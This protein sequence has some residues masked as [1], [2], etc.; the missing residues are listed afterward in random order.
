MLSL[1]PC[2]TPFLSPFPPSSP[3]LL[4]LPPLL[5]LLLRKTLAGYNLTNLFIGSEGTLGI[6][7]E[8]TL[9]LYGIPESVK[10]TNFD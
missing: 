1:S 7:T 10:N 4:S 5:S 2:L 3:S 8:A 9:R 6:I